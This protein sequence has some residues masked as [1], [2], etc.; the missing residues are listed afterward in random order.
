[1]VLFEHSSSSLSSNQYRCGNEAEC[2]RRTDK[3]M[4]TVY[5]AAETVIKHS[6]NR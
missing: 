6:I 5:Q 4:A 2:H 3:I 1:M